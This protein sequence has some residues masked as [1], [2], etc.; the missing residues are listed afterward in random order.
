VKLLGVLLANTG[1]QSLERTVSAAALNELGIGAD[2]V[3]DR[4]STWSPVRVSP[5]PE[6][7]RFVQCKVRR[8]LEDD[9]SVYLAVDTVTGSPLHGCC[10]NREEDLGNGR[11]FQLALEV[12]QPGQDG[13]RETVR[14]GIGS[15]RMVPRSAFGPPSP[16]TVIVDVGNSRTSVG[17]LDDGPSGCDLGRDLSL[18]RLGRR[19]PSYSRPTEIVPSRMDL[20]LPEWCSEG[21]VR[22]IA[23]LFGEPAPGGEPS[24]TRRLESSLLFREHSLARLGAGPLRATV[25]GGVEQ[26][27]RTGL[28]SPKRYLWSQEREADPWYAFDPARTGG[29]R[30][31]P[32]RGALLRYVGSGLT[33]PPV[34]DFTK[35]DLVM[36]FIFE[37]LVQ[38]HAE[39]NSWEFRRA[40]GSNRARWMESVV[41]T[42]PSNMTGAELEIFEQR[43]RTAIEALHE[44]VLERYDHP[45]PELRPFDLD[46]GTVAQLPHVLAQLQRGADG[47]HAWVRAV[48]DG[49]SITL[50]CLD[51]GGGSIDASL[52]RYEAREAVVP[53]SLQCEL[54]HVDGVSVGGDDIM[55]GL[56]E[57]I[58]VDDMCRAMRID[59]AKLDQLVTMGRAARTQAADLGFATRVLQDVLYPIALEYVR[60]AEGHRVS[61]RL[62]LP[63]L[64]GLP[65]HVLARCRQVLESDGRGVPGTP[66]DQIVLTFDERRFRAVVGRVIGPSL[67]RLGR[68]LAARG[69]AEIV[70]AGRLSVLD[71]VRDLVRESTQ[72]DAER[73]VQCHR[74]ESLRGAI[75]VRPRAP[76]WVLD[77]KLAVVLGA[78]I[79]EAARQNRLVDGVKLHL[80]RH[81]LAASGFTW[82][83]VST[84]TRRF[85]VRSPPLFEPG[86]T[87]DGDRRCTMVVNGTLLIGRRLTRDDELEATPVYELRP[88]EAGHQVHTVE[89]SCEFDGALRDEVVTAAVDGCPCGPSSTPVR[90]G[91]RT[92]YEREY[93]LDRPLSLT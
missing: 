81:E 41:F 73:V 18:V 92:L 64:R 84:A 59:P 17:I 91:L 39:I 53:L 10:A 26:G 24:V 3:L 44:L 22:T 85:V 68:V 47:F 16:V 2:V 70:L 50:G 7:H 28:S 20:S 29:N 58:I 54:L 46:E 93:W 12:E 8:D 42:Y 55:R 57:E 37:L 89:L 51:I 77:P 31:Q 23:G 90:F 13:A 83:E 36:L 72:L 43:A 35:S 69:A 75:R 78:A 15:L 62:A 14:I 74:I 61:D 52:V 5:S 60:M 79:A 63:E 49:P 19:D 1:I 6:S 27:S 48:A 30:L 34:A 66:F 11:S 88:A 38:T 45:R 67:C 71:L 25:A 76:G 87:E 4:Y 21:P 40:K 56:I 65:G 82:G 9:L 32:P 86:D 33:S 80:G